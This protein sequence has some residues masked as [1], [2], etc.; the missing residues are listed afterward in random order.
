MCKDSIET[1]CEKCN[2]K[3]LSVRIELTARESSAT[4]CQLSHEGRVS[5]SMSWA[6]H[7]IRGVVSSILTDKA[8]ELHFSQVVSVES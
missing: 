6:Y 4:L 8:L 1:S 3:A 5:E 7:E 2:S